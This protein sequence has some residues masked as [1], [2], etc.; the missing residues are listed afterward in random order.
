[1]TTAP[2]C[3]ATS[4]SCPAAPAPRSP[5]A[6]RSTGET[7][8]PALLYATGRLRLRRPVIRHRYARRPHAL[9]RLEAGPAE[10][11]RRPEGR[12]RP[13]PG[14]PPV[15][16]R[17][18]PAAPLTGAAAAADRG[19]GAGRPARR[20][21]GLLPP[22]TCAARRSATGS[23]AASSAASDGEPHR[24]PIRTARSPV[25]GMLLSWLPPLSLR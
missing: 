10:E 5:S 24:P 9:R 21:R 1:R 12:L 18:W 16:C 3:T 4:R 23:P 7:A 11:M 19:G 6:A 20:G 25:H 15:R 2:T 14:R 17:P 22:P 8:A 13:R